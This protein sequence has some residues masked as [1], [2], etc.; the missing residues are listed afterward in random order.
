MTRMLSR[1]KKELA[2]LQTIDTFV[3]IG[4]L[5]AREEE[6]KS[7]HSKKTAAE[8][9]EKQVKESKSTK[10]LKKLKITLAE[11]T[12]TKVSVADTPSTQKE[13]I[14]SKTGVFRRIKMKSKHKS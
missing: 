3:E 2:Y 9:S 1:N 11:L 14:P 12:K 4:V 13:I 8:S 5:L 10:S 6:T 7:K